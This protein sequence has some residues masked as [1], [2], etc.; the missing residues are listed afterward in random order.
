VNRKEALMNKLISQKVEKVKRKIREQ[1]GITTEF[2]GDNITIFGGMHLFSKF[3]KKLKVEETLES[4]VSLQRR[5]NKYSVG[6]YLL[7]LIYGTVLQLN[8]LSDTMLL[9]ADKVFQRIVGLN[10]YPHQTSLSRFLWTF[11]A[12]MAREI[13]MVNVL[14]LNRMRNR[15]KG[16]TKVTLDFDSHVKTVYGEQQRAKKGYNPKKP[17]RKSYHPLLCFLGE[18]RDFLW[19]KFRPGDSYSGSGAVEFF[20]QSLRFIPPH[21][22]TIFLRGDSGFYDDKFLTMLER[23]RG[24][25]VKYAIAVKLY[26]WIQSRLA[27]VKYH[28]IGNGFEAGEFRYKSPL[29]KYGIER[30][31]V[32]VREKIKEEKKKELLLFELAGY[33]YEVIVTDIES[34]TPEEVWHFYNGRANVENMIKEGVIGYG[35]DVTPTHY[36][37]ANVAHFFLVMLSYNLMNWYKEFVLGL[38]KVKRMAKWVRQRFLLI[39]GKLVSSGRRQILKLW[40]DYPWKEEYKEAEEKLSR[41]YLAG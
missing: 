3:V 6:K 15:F 33:N 41:I 10:D 37:G 14:L 29:D 21:I 11:T 35:L 8:R 32:V 1:D 17:G 20:R 39:G 31:M 2:T 7:C 36:W 27:G 40:R 26:P 34:S 5:E 19:G 9:R 28:K 16:M 23:V 24:R 25:V 13:G 38:E 18:T 30:R 4:T 12:P 22:E